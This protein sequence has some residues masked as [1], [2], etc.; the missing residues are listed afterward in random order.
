MKNIVLLA[1]PALLC[2]FSCSQSEKISPSKEDN[3]D[4]KDQAKISVIDYR[5]EMRN[6]V[7][8]ISQYAKTQNPQFAIIP[9]NGIELITTNGESTGSLAQAYVNAID[10]V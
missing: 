6:F 5:E 8:G 2:L 4:L 7:I 10:A 3:P 9:Q 1:A